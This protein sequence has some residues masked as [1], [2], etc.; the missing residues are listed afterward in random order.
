MC[1]YRHQ[2]PHLMKR[3]IITI[4]FLELI[5][6]NIFAQLPQHNSCGIDRMIS[7]EELS[8]L[9][10]HN[11]TIESKYEYLY[12]YLDN[13]KRIFNQPY[14]KYVLRD[15]K[16]GK[17]ASS[18]LQRIH[19]NT[20]RVI[21]LDVEY[22]HQLVASSTYQKALMIFILAHEIQHHTNGDLHYEENTQSSNYIKE[23]LAD[24][25]AGYA[26]A[27]L[28]SANIDF[29]EEVLPKILKD[30]VN[31]QTHPP[32]IFR[33]MSAKAGWIRGK[34]ENKTKSLISIKGKNYQRSVYA[35]GVEIWGESARN[36][37]NGVCFER[38]RQGD[39]FIGEKSNGLKEGKGF[40]IK[41]TQEGEELFYGEFKYNKPVQA[42]KD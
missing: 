19:N 15:I 10:E 7:Q 37:Y 12:H 26:V 17:M 41:Q 20:P 23:L 16:N 25:R 4:L 32:R 42:I 33:L 22:Y 28:T 27:K 30:K 39:I 1:V 35:T 36:T 21:T 9:I 6:L 29:F 14:A 11:Q 38:N 34:L 8:K 2:L 18:H 24:E 40:L 31:S 13:I 3:T 5:V